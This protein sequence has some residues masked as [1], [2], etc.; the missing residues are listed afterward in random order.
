[1]EPSPAHLAALAAIVDRGTFDAAAQELHVTPSAISQRIRALE[2]AAGQ[3]LVTRGTPCRPTPAGETLLRLAR[4]SRLLWEEARSEL[5]E[6]ERHVVDLAV[7]VN[8]DSLATWLRPLLEIV[9]GWRRTSL[10][11]HVEDEAYSARLLRSGEV[12]AAVTSEP[13]TIQGCV[14]EPLGRLR[15]RPAASPG[16]VERWRRGRGVDWAAMPVVVFNEKDRLQQRIL[17]QRGVEHP[18]T[19]AHRVPTSSDY[20]AAVVCGL[21]WGA[22]PE[23]QLTPALAE[24]TLVPLPGAGWLAV[25][26]SWQRWRLDSPAL[27][28]LTA[29]VHAAAAHG[30]TT[31]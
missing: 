23:P 15:Y 13:T 21:G 25:P 28:R 26:L 16:F 3:V 11:L 8:A 17:E 1:M 24:G 19:V 4:Q 2:S 14:V 22:I 6:D 31:R 30:L 12:L 7:A 9:A 29:A 27:D 18:P 5:S 20:L 10:R